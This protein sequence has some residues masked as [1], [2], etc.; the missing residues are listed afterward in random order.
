VF[1][2]EAGI[3]QSLLSEFGNDRRITG[4]RNFCSIRCENFLSNRENSATLVKLAGIRVASEPVST[5]QLVMVPF[6]F[7]FT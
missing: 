2:H 4:Q 6:I 1:G 5:R 3:Y 7:I